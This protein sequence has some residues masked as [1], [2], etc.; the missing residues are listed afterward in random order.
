MRHEFMFSN[1]SSK[2]K[3]IES[4]DVWALCTLLSLFSCIISRGLWLFIGGSDTTLVFTFV[5]FKIVTISPPTSTSTTTVTSLTTPTS[6]RWPWTFTFISI[7]APSVW[8][9][10][11]LI[12]FI[13]GSLVISEV[14]P[15]RGRLR[16]MLIGWMWDILIS[17]W[18]RLTFVRPCTW[19]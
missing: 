18:S 2:W 4:K 17:G 3:Y 12:S 13:R 15:L 9:I 1:F 16:V 7:I 5:S 11:I 19:K 14:L 10:L 6:A 8:P